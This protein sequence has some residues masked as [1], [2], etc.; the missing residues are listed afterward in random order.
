MLSDHE[1]LVVC[2]VGLC[3]ILPKF[4]GEKAAPSKPASTE[5]VST[6]VEVSGL[7]HSSTWRRSDAWRPE[8]RPPRSRL[9][10]VEAAEVRGLVCCCSPHSVEVNPKHQTCDL[11]WLPCGDPVE[12][13]KCLWERSLAMSLTSIEVL[14]GG[15]YVFAQHCGGRGEKKEEEGGG[16]SI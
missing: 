5:E 11:R 1:W 9:A 10:I 13:V 2:F 4:G 16:G 14:V 6:T 12:D 8:K 15:G 3:R 7:S